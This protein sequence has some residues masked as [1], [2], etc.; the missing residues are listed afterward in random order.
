MVNCVYHL[1]HTHTHTHTHMRHPQN[2]FFISSLPDHNVSNGIAEA[3][4]QRIVRAH[5][6]KKVFRVYIVMPLL[7]SFEG[8]YPLTLLRTGYL[9]I[10]YRIH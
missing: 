3:L 1:I 7:P 5:R 4:R 9:M 10:E 6:E 8:W 2:Q